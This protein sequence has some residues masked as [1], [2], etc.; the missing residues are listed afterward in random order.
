MN[1]DALQGNWKQLRGRVKE[2][3]GNLTDDDLDRIDGRT[4]RLIGVLQEKYGY[5]KEKAESEIR[6]LTSDGDDASWTA[7]KKRTG[8]A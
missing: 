4:E 7:G 2:M 8:N 6:R 5:A 1:T 3:W